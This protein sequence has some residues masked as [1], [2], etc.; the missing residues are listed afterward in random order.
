MPAVVVRILMALATVVPLLSMHIS[1]VSS[2]QF[3]LV[4]RPLNVQPK[5]G[6]AFPASGEIR[7]STE[8][9]LPDRWNDHLAIVG[10]HLRR[11]TADQQRFTGDPQAE[12]ASGRS[13]R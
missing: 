7:L 12:S 13:A 1:T 10:S 2:Q 4:P 6:Q 5:T 3:A 9:E 11:L 8:S